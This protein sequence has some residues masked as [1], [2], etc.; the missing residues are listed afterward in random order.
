MMARKTRPARTKTKKTLAGKASRK[1]LA[2]AKGK[3]KAAKTATPATRDALD[4]MV[5][6]A[7]KALAL[8]CNPAWMPSIKANLEIILRQAALVDAFA[9]PDEVEPAPVFEA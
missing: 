2:K 1:P 8:K 6:A 9:L 3:T 4:D 7:A 5:D